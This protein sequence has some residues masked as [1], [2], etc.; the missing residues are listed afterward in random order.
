MSSPR[1]I[2]RKLKKVEESE[3]D[4][5]IKESK[6][7]KEKEEVFDVE[8]ILGFKHDDG[9]KTG[10]ISEDM[11]VDPAIS[12]LTK[13]VGYPSDYN[14][15][16]CFKGMDSEETVVDCIAREYKRA[17]AEVMKEA[18]TEK[19]YDEQWANF[20]KR[21][22]GYVSSL[23]DFFPLAAQYIDKSNAFCRVRVQTLTKEFYKRVVKGEAIRERYR[24]TWD[25]NKMF[26]RCRAE[27]FR[28][29]YPRME[30]YKAPREATSD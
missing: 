12:F 25:G 16:T 4:A 28:R 21:K 29:K 27:E 2:K 1:G 18:L 15:F 22:V 8:D 26:V 3:D 10:L 9:R 19:Q 23:L 24:V 20:R 14:K 13:W 11:L 30:I 17:R 5:S 6:N 7:G